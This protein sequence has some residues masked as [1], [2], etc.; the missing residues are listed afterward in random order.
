MKRCLGPAQNCMHFC[1]K[2]ERDLAI[3][4][5]VELVNKSTAGHTV[6]CKA[7]KG[8]SL[9][10]WK[11]CLVCW[12]CFLPHV[13]V[14]SSY[15][16]NQ[17]LGSS[18]TPITLSL[19]TSVV[20]WIISMWKNSF[21]GAVV[22]S[23]GNWWPRTWWCFCSTN[24][25]KCLLP[26]TNHISSASI[27]NGDLWVCISEGFLV[28]KLDAA[29]PLCLSLFPPK[30]PGSIPPL[31]PCISSAL[32]LPLFN[33]CHIFQTPSLTQARWGLYLSAQPPHCT[34]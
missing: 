30:I 17:R 23:V 24:P 18:P 4:Q 11:V 10:Q 7:A 26:F 13:L 1:G 9:P 8:L 15:V 29:A 27:R 22:Q 31:L 25:K 5:R 33:L 19:G 3:K 34:V 12:V 6:A 20:G 21:L 16:H 14:P 28:F 2:E 32:P